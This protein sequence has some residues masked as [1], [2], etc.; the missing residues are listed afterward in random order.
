M[1][2]QKTASRARLHPADRFVRAFA[3]VVRTQYRTRFAIYGES[4]V[5][6]CGDAIDIARTVS[7]RLKG[8]P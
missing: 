7:A 4:T 6:T 3:M 5:M 1:K 2:Q 8:K